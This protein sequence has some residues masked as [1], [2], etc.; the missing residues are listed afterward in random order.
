MSRNPIKAG[1]VAAMLAAASGCAIDEGYELPE[2]SRSSG[3]AYVPY[4]PYPPG[5]YGQGG[6][7]YYYGSPGYRPNYYGYYS[8]FA[9]QDGFYP[10]GGYFNPYPSYVFVPC[11]DS[12]HDGRCDRPRG[13]G[14]QGHGGGNGHGNGNGGGGGHHNGGGN[15]SNDGGHDGR[16]RNGGGGTPQARP[17]PTP[18]VNPPQAAQP[19]QPKPVE[20]PA[21]PAPPRPMRD[22][23][24][25]RTQHD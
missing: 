15:H 11:V 7:L 8:P 13:H 12:N 14:G 16:P 6:S 9:Y 23:N 24:N 18:R 19:R 21:A 2:L 25:R 3:G 1:L 20:P 10:Y 4:A 22:D 17:T 5:Y